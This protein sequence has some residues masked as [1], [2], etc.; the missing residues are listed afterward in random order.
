MNQLLRYIQSAVPARGPADVPDQ[1]LL[2]RFARDRDE[3][4][5]AALV[6]RYGGAVWS[7]CR[8]LVDREQDAEDAFQ[9][10]FLTLARKAASIRGGASI[11]AWL[12]GVARRVA[13]NLRRDARRQADTEAAAA[14][15]GRR[16][17]ADLTWQEGLAA[18]E[19]EL[20]HL[21]G[22]Y[23]AVLIACCLAGRSRDEAAAHLGWSQGQVKG[24]LERAREVLRRRLESRGLGLARLLTAAAAAPAALVAATVKAAAPFGAGSGGPGVASA[25]VALLVE[26]VLQ[27]MSRTKLKIVTAVVLVLGTLGRG[28]GLLSYPRAAEGPSA[29]GGP[30][31]G[32]APRKAAKAAGQPKAAEGERPAWGTARKGLRLGLCRADVKGEGKVCLLAVVENVST[33]DLIVN[34]GL[35]LGNGKKQLP[36][37]VRLVFTDAGGKERALRRK[38]GGVAGRVDPFGV[39]LAAGC[40]YT[41]AC[42]LEDYLDEDAARA[43]EP[44][45]PGRYR[46]RAEFVG[47]APS[48]D[49][50]GLALMTYWTGTVESNVFP[51]TWPAKPAK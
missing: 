10:T 2:G 1:D 36:T 32:A 3:A 12:H 37:A 19:E 33:E 50:T 21:P 4:A 49:T 25:K 46:A 18:L 44:L 6:G 7:V 26:G 34:L 31:D 9:A 27:S 45:A 30:G 43:G 35:M 48:I 40:R 29:A 47:K 20:A 24:R 42:D 28:A 5:F 39:P 8:R 41:I 38:V 23:R 15:L 51:I 11:S 13:A 22:R 16:G 17:G 14:A